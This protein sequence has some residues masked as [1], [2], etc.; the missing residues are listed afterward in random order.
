MLLVRDNYS[1]ALHLAIK[2]NS[3][4]IAQINGRNF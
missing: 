4:T 1:I 3:N 2:N